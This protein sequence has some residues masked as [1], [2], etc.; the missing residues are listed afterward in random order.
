ML[1]SIVKSSES[2]TVLSTCPD[3]HRSKWAEGLERR[4][5]ITPILKNVLVVTIF[6][7]PAYVLSLKVLFPLSQHVY[8]KLSQSQKYN[9]N[10]VH[11]S[12]NPTVCTLLTYPPTLYFIP[13]FPC[14]LSSLLRKLKTQEA[15]CTGERQ[16]GLH[17][18]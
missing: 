17:H 5:Y 16:C 13:S 2:Q 4:I 6:K 8:I 14:Q 9:I 15:D 1:V 10:P 11:S 7:L 3:R 12:Q 18:G